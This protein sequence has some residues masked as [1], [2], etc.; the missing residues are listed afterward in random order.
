VTYDEY[1][2][3]DWW[4]GIKQKIYKRYMGH[5]AKCFATKNLETHHLRYNDKDG[6][7]WFREKLSDLTLLCRT[8]HYREHRMKKGWRFIRP[9]DVMHF[10]W[11]LLVY[12][13]S[14]PEYPKQSRRIRY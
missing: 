12:T 9:S 11:T 8:C 3:T 6:S 10:V 1:L 5:C 7:L 2:R 14:I 4:Q 13:Y